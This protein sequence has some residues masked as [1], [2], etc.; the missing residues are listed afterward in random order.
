VIPENNVMNYKIADYMM[1][2]TEDFGMRF[3]YFPLE[4]GKISVEVDSDEDEIV[5]RQIHRTRHGLR[6][7]DTGLQGLNSMNCHVR[8]TEGGLLMHNRKQAVTATSNRFASVN[9]VLSLL[10][11]YSARAMAIQSAQVC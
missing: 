11:T 2:R 8:P 9:A 3:E 4:L 1:A 10:L 7:L 6:D 5:H